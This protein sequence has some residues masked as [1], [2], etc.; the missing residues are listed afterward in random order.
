MYSLLLLSVL[1]Q[2]APGGAQ[3]TQAQ[4]RIDKGN[5][6]ITMINVID[7]GGAGCYGSGLPALPPRDGGDPPKKDTDKVAVKVKVTT[8]AVISAEMPAKSVEAYTT[9]GKAISAE[10]LANLL[11]KER[12][13]LVALD[14]KKVDPFHLQVYKDG[15]I[16]LV[17]PANTLNRHHGGLGGYYQP[18]TERYD[19][20]PRDTIPPE[21]FKK[22]DPREII[23]PMPQLDPKRD[24]P[25][26]P[27]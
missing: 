14:G 16:V 20:D 5:L 19:D 26:P 6:T 11:T 22:P 18:R 2:P 10:T 25:R 21:R 1:A 27:Q 8:L 23:P 7:H 12:T 4:A 17:P 9:D 15:T 3:P 24:R 13:V